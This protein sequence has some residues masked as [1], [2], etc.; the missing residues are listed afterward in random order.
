M[1]ETY[2]ALAATVQA[3]R[4]RAGDLRAA[5]TR[6]AEDETRHAALSWQIASWAE[7]RLGPTA[8]ARVATARAQAIAAL[9]AELAAQR[10]PCELLVDAGEPTAVE[11]VRLLDA[12]TEAL[13][14]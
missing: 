6:I 10:V 13:A 11:A 14:A 12:L 2:A 1:R 5:M 9:R 7:R 8:R 3:T 4:A